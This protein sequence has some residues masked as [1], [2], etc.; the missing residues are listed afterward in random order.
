MTP[1]SANR[2]SPEFALLGFLYEGPGHGYELHQRLHDEFGDIWHAS[3]SQTYNIL[4]RLESQG[5]IGSRTV[6]QK[7]LPPRRLIHITEAGR[8][9]FDAWLNRPTGSSVHAIRVEFITRL[10]F[11]QRFYPARTGT[12]IQAE[13]AEVNAGLRRLEAILADV[14]A[15][16]RFDRLGLA[17]RIRQLNAVLDWLMECRE[18]F[19]PKTT[20]SRSK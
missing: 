20:R 16:K 7:K 3:Q 6:E 12:V 2:L 10:Y 18:A 11:F 19:N 1:P 9:R 17:L 13:I 4:K 5:Y 14:P 15:S 8:Q